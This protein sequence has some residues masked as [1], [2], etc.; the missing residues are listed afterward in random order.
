MLFF[1][2]LI[3]IGII[4]I[5][6]LR[7]KQI[8]QRCDDH[9]NQICD[10]GEDIQHPEKIPVYI[11]FLKKHSIRITKLIRTNSEF[12]KKLENFD[13]KLNFFVNEIIRKKRD[14]LYRQQLSTLLTHTIKD[15]D[16]KKR[17]EKT[18]SL[19]CVVKNL[20]N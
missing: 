3:I 10:N 11:S 8:M 4:I 5:S 19:F 15:K 18:S 9:I 12:Q 17:G 16:L 14:S 7:I 2:F 1:V 13:Y 20:C 6:N